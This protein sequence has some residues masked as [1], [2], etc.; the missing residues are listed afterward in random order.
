MED[1][2]FAAA[3]MHGQTVTIDA[4]YVKT[5]LGEIAGDT[6]LSRYIL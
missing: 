2:S 1:L 3:D 6:D 5:R 4:D